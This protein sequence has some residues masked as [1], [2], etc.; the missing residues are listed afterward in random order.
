VEFLVQDRDMSL[1]VV[2][3]VM[4]LRILKNWD[5]SCLSYDQLKTSQVL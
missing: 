5:I 1:A 2:N 3:K 4:N